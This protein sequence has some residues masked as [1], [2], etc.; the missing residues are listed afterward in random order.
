[1]RPSAGF[2][3]S[4]LVSVSLFAESAS[5]Q[6]LKLAAE[7]AASRQART[8]PPRSVDPPLRGRK[9]LLLNPAEIAEAGPY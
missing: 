4:V 9:A 5:G 1:M 3:A 8:Q 7:V 6:I 2:D